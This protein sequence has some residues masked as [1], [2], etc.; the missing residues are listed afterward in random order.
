MKPFQTKGLVRRVTPFM[1]AGLIALVVFSDPTFSRLAWA[2]ALAVVVAA[3]VIATSLAPIEWDRLPRLAIAAPI[4]VA[5]LLALGATFTQGSIV[6]LAAGAAGVVV[7]VAIYALPWDR[8]PRWIHELPVF[9]G[10]VAV[11]VIQATVHPTGLRS[12]GGTPCFPAVS[13]L[14]FVRGALRHKQS[15]GGNDRTRIGR[16]PGPF[17]KRRQSTRPAGD[18][19][20][21]RGGALGRRSHRARRR[22]SAEA[23]RRFRPSAQRPAG[24]LAR[25]PAGDRGHIAERHRGHG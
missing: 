22:R 10:I 16:N 3:G 14:G 25:T 17:H 1:G 21:G 8:L 6:A 9:G 24:E 23:L 15:G 12:G 19:N 13:D 11:F 20:P 7:I 5:L 18:L 4:V 2:D